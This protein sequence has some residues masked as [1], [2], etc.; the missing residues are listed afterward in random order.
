MHVLAMMALEIGRDDEYGARSYRAAFAKDGRLVTT[1]LDG[2]LRLYNDAFRR[3]AIM[4]TDDG[5]QPY[6]VAFSPDGEFVAV[7]GAKVRAETML[8]SDTTTGTLI[9]KS[10]IEIATALRRS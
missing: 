6:G 5:A 9:T 10:L 1:C 2:H 7:G 3:V 4:R 8:M